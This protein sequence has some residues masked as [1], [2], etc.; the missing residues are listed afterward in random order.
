M[1]TLHFMYLHLLVHSCMYVC[2][3]TTHPHTLKRRALMSAHCTHPNSNAPE[4][5]FAQNRKK[6]SFARIS[7]HLKTKQQLYS[8]HF[9]FTGL[10]RSFC[11]ITNCTQ[12]RAILEDEYHSIKKTKRK[13]TTRLFKVR[14]PAVRGGSWAKWKQQQIPLN[15]MLLQCYGEMQLHEAPSTTVRRHSLSKLHGYSHCAF[16]FKIFDFPGQILGN[17]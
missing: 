8:F 17:F 14:T 4:S 6:W 1:T 12:I 16:T 3:L 10:N 9:T 11:D 5:N 15:W 13:Q 2:L 7:T